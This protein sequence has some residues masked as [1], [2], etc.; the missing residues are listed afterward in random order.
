MNMRNISIVIAFFCT[1]STM[2]QIKMH[3]VI[4]SMPDSIVPYLTQ[5]NRLDMLDFHDNH[6]SAEIT[7]SFGGK[8]KLVRLTDSYALI[9]LNDASQ[10]ELRLL[11]DSSMTDV[12]RQVI[13][14]VR[15]MGTTQKESV[16]LFFDPQWKPLSTDKYL[17]LP[18][19][20]AS[21]TN[22]G[23]FTA[24]LDEEKQILT[25]HMKDVL[26]EP[27]L[28]E[29]RKSDDLQIILNWRGCFVKEG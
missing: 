1:I 13:C 9:L 21:S 2:A 7:N 14:V 15:T 6:M 22:V 19:S 17:Q 4:R 5:N 24:Q 18:S 8:S 3:D 20:V 27:V 12:T 23:G 25:I 10:M 16:I 26:A 28:E 11:N 29:Q